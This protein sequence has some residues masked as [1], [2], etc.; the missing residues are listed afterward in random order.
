MGVISKRHL[1]K[2]RL[3]RNA[4]KDYNNN[5]N[6]KIKIDGRSLMIIVGHAH[7]CGIY[8]EPQ[9]ILENLKKEEKECIYGK[10]IAKLLNL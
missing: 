3:V 1:L 7:A 9:S 8:L 4:E 10:N 5:W 6:K 2:N